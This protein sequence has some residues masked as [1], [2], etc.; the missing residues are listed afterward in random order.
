[1]LRLACPPI[2]IRVSLRARYFLV[3]P[4]NMKM[5]DVKALIILR[6]PTGIW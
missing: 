5:G 6:L 4:I 3:F 2:A 1:M